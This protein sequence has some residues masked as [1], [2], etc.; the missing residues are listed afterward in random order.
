MKSLILLLPF[1]VFFACKPREIPNDVAARASGKYIVQSY[2]VNGDTLYTSNGI[3]KIGIKEF[4]IS[5]GRTKPDSLQVV[6]FCKNNGDTGASLFKYVG[7][8]EVNGGFRLTAPTTSSAYESSI[9]DNVFYERMAI[10]GGAYLM[11]LPG[12]S[13][14]SPNSPAVEGVIISAEK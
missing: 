11:V 8:S 2:T 6:T 9:T 3:N 7:V 1:L 13:L 14:K 12:Y 10:G 4:Y 5:V